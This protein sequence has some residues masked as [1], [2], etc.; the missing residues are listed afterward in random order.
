M[1]EVPNVLT[2][3]PP[4]CEI[5]EFPGFSVCGGQAKKNGNMPMPG[6]K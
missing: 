1:V 6:R 4:A 2:V 3:L 5:G